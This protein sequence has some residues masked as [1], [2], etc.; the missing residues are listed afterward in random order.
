MQMY[1]A[2]VGPDIPP[3]Y[4]SIT[5]APLLFKCDYVCHNLNGGAEENAIMVND[6]MLVW[7]AR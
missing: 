7:D 1:S 2:L 3:H 6:S 5:F 4:I